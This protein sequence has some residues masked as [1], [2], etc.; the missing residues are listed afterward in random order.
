MK[1]RLFPSSQITKEQEDFLLE[2]FMHGMAAPRIPTRRRSLVPLEGDI[3]SE[4]AQLERKPNQLQRA[5][6]A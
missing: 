2:S 5:F 6:E 1:N 3:P 4:V